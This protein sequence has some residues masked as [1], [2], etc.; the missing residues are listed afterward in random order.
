MHC[1]PITGQL[2]T[3]LRM[4]CFRDDPW[5]VSDIKVTGLA[6]IVGTLS[7]FPGTVDMYFTAWEQPCPNVMLKYII[8]VHRTLGSNPQKC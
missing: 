4:T 8:H 3:D 6:H 7:V 2:W 5:L 1:A